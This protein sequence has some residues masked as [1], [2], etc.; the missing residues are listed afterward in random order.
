MLTKLLRI[1]ALFVAVMSL[2][3]ASGEDRKSKNPSLIIVVEGLRPEYLTRSMM[4]NLHALSKRGVLF[5]EHRAVF[6]TLSGVNAASIVTGAYPQTHGLLGDTVL[7][8]EAGAHSTFDVRDIKSLRIAEGAQDGGLLTATTLGEVFRDRDLTFLVVGAGPAA[9]PYLLGRGGAVIHPEFGEPESLQADVINTLSAPRDESGHTSW[10]IDTYLNICL[11]NLKPNLAILW[12]SDSGLTQSEVGDSRR[13]EWMRKIDEQIGRIL[14]RHKKLRMDINVFVTSDHGAS[15]RTERMDLSQ[16]LI[17]EGLKADKHSRDVVVLGNCSIVVEG[18]DRKRIRQIVERLQRVDWVGAIY[19]QQRMRTHPE[20][21]V[22]GALSFQAVYMAHPRAPD[23]LVE[24]AWSDDEN[25]H[26]YSGTVQG[27]GS[28][29]S[30]ASSPFDLDVILVA[31]G[32][33]FKRGVESSVPS[34][35][36]DLAPTVC[37]LQGIDPP[38]SMEGRVLH[39]ALSGG[40]KPASIEVLHRRH[41]SQADWDGGRYRIIMTESSVDGVDYLAFTKVE[42]L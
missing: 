21:F 1:F 24:P 26:G 18:H 9:T 5:D 22:P 25:A 37:F 41:G 39:E 14:K 34:A 40:P 11:P 16:F 10:L 31:A 15:T 17:D 33:D 2:S 19:T 32:P 29:E 4:P 36:I 20:S 8:P 27:F 6:P 42:G 13:A 38:A 7:L 23:I 3:S 12:V 35:H 30:G 28:G